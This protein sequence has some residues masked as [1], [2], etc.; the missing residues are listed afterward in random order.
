MGPVLGISLAFSFGISIHSPTKLA[1][2]TCS[3][4]ISVPKPPFSPSVATLLWSALFFISSLD[5]L[6]VCQSLASTGHS[7]PH[8]V[9][10]LRGRRDHLKILLT[11]PKTLK[12]VVES[13]SLL[14]IIQKVFGIS[15]QVLLMMDTVFSFAV[16]SSCLSVLQALILPRILTYVPATSSIYLL[17][18]TLQRSLSIHFLL[19]PVWNFN[20]LFHNFQLFWCVFFPRKVLSS[21]RH[22]IFSEELCIHSLSIMQHSVKQQMVMND[23]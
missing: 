3:H 2:L 20:S 16:H 10:F 17:L 12:K 6:L 7:E 23:D 22:A 8:C 1:K 21:M 15:F 18:L 14:R 4:C 5:Y 9:S 13:S 19:E 11:C